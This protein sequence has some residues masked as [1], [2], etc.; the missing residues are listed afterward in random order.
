MA[1]NEAGYQR[2]IPRDL[3]NESKLLKCVG[4][5]ALLIHDGKDKNGRTTPPALKVEH[6]GGEFRIDQRPEDG[7]LYV[8]VHFKVKSSVL[9]VYLAY[10]SKRSYPLLCM[11]AECEELEVLYDDGTLTDEFCEYVNNL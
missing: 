10:N 2:I 6:S 9:D 7:G 5:L 1:A 8:N 4:Q 3:F 11:T